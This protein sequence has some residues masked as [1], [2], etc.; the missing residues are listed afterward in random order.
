MGSNVPVI[1]ESMNEM[2]HILFSWLEHRTGIPRSRVET[3][4]KS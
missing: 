3:P 1:N 4:F 2:N